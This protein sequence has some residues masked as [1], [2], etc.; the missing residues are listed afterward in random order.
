MEPEL[1][2]PS[3]HAEKLTARECEAVAEVVASEVLYLQDL[4]VRADEDTWLGLATDYLAE[5][6]PGDGA[7]ASH[8]G[9]VNAMRRALGLAPVGLGEWEAIRELAR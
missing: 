6:L 7:I 8:L 9:R 1:K 4:M 5:Q 3:L 2:Y